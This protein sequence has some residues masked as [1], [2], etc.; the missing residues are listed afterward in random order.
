MGRYTVHF[1]SAAAQTLTGHPVQMGEL[2]SMQLSVLC[3]GR[4]PR[5]ALFCVPSMA[6]MLCKH[7]AVDCEKT[8]E[9]VG[10]K[11]GWRDCPC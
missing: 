2:S 10:E 3:R 6:Q 11:R 4:W 7:D 9:V 5:K 1:R 8:P